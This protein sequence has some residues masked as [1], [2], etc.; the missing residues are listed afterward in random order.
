MI[1][2][3]FLSLFIVKNMYLCGHKKFMRK[4]LF[5]RCTTLLHQCVNIVKRGTSKEIALATHAIG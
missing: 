5:F 4:P 1:Y 3:F 2:I